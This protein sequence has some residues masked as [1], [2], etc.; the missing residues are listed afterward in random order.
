MS[1]TYRFK[2]DPYLIKD[3]GVLS[4]T[5]FRF[6]GHIQ[7]EPNSKEG[8]QRLARFHS[9]AKRYVM[10]WNGPS[11]WHKMTSQVP[12]RVR[13]R[14]QINKFMRGQEEDVIIESYPHREY[15][16]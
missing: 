14:N 7:H 11:W 1:R 10:I 8:C 9:D 3:R 13:A 16:W 12:Y 15:Y 2:K 6:G 4:E 5:N